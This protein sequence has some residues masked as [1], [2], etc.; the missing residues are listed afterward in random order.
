M[1][2]TQLFAAT[3]ALGLLAASPAGADPQVHE[4]GQERPVSGMVTG[5]DSDD[6]TIWVGPMRFN[7][8]SGVFDLDELSE[9]A[10]VVVDY[11]RGEDG[12]VATGLRV[13]PL[14]R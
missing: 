5:I 13:D 8:P 1:R 9:D 2:F 3:L 4:I 11:R 10:I 7:I 6:R 12:L 14:P